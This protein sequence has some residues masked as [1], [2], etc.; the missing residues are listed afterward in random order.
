MTSALLPASDH[1]A[2]LDLATRYGLALDDWDFDA[3]LDCW[4]DDGKL[5]IDHV[6]T[7]EGKA[8]IDAWIRDYRGVADGHRHHFSQHLL[9]SHGD[10]AA[11][12]RSYNLLI[13]I[14]GADDLPHVR[15]SGVFRDKLRRDDTG[16][17]FV[18]RHLGEIVIR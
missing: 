7:F 10:N 12:M 1:I 6:G 4:A 11:T 9:R 16:W 2:V 18:E 15:L 3:Y 8:A 5:T 13:R 17:R 14:A